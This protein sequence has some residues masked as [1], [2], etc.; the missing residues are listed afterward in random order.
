M[1]REITAKL[2][3]WTLLSFDFFGLI[4]AATLAIVLLIALFLR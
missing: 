4:P 2:E 3:E 1:D